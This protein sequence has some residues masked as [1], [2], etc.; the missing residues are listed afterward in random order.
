MLIILD[1]GCAETVGEQANKNVKLLVRIDRE[2]QE[3]IGISGEKNLYNAGYYF[4]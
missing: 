2:K 4:A 1:L 3:V